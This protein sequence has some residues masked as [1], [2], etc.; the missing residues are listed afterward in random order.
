MK[1]F[2]I[3]ILIF[4]LAVVIVDQLFGFAGDYMQHHAKTG[5]IQQFDDFLLKDTHEVIIMGSSRAHHHYVPDTLEAFLH[6]DVYNAGADGNGVIYAYEALSLIIQRYAP[7]IIIY[8]IEP[9]FDINIY[10]ND[11]ERKTYLVPFKPYYRNSSIATIFKDISSTEFLKAHSGFCRYNSQIIYL[12]VE[13]IKGRYYFPNGYYPMTGMMDCD[14]R[15]IKNVAETCDSVKVRYL[16]FFVN[17]CLSNE[18]KLY[19][20]FSPRW[21]DVASSTYDIVEN[22]AQMYNIPV[23]DYTNMFENSPM[24]FKEPMHLNDQGA[25]EFSRIIS[26]DI[27]K[28]KSCKHTVDF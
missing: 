11:Q 13:F 16:E 25:R 10:E 1:R 15:K 22:I 27:V 2:V 28:M 20:A 23:L 18:I 3:D 5:Q 26:S 6:K 12:F 24:Y 4:F 17:Q 9:S 7:E 21:G 14:R 8:D 19:F